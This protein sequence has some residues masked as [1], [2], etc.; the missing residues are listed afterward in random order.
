MNFREDMYLFC[1]IWCYSMLGWTEMRFRLFAIHIVGRVSKDNSRQCADLIACRSS[2]PPI[3]VYN[4][5]YAVKVSQGV[6]SCLI[7]P[8]RRKPPDPNS[9]A[10]LVI[11]ACP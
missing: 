5:M 7:L 1:M 10:P 4:R 3:E 9:I 11:S 8:S 6:R 2:K